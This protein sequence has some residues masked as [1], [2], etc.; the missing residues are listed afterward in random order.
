MLWNLLFSVLLLAFLI[1]IDLD[2]FRYPFE[3]KIFPW[4]I[5]IPATLLMF[6][7]IGKD[8]SRLRRGS[9]EYEQAQ[10]KAGDPRAFAQ[11]IGWMACFPIMIYVLGFFVGIPLFVFLYM[12]N[13]GMSWLRSSGL[14][15]GSI[16]VIYLIFSLGMEVRFDP[17]LIYSFLK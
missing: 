10:K 2:A 14:A 3:T 12:K 16:I 9:E 15:A 8:I 6:I 11:I 13:H 17:G 7:Q 4:V 5:G 1:A